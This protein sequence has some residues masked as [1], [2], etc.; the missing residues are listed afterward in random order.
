MRHNIT[1]PI[2]VSRR[3]GVGDRRGRVAGIAFRARWL[4][5]LTELSRWIEG[6]GLLLRTDLQG[7]DEV[8]RDREIAMS[9]V[10]DILR[11]PRDA[12]LDFCQSFMTFGVWVAP[13]RD[14]A[15]FG[16]VW[17]GSGGG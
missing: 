8:W 13:R 17:A 9:R 11:R 3:K 12:L 6:W 16:W 10:Y 5:I 14:R 7:V 2:G 15:C 4:H 1:Q